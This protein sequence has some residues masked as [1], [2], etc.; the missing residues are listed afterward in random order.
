MNP[1]LCQK[2]RAQFDEFLDGGLGPE[3][4]VFITDHLL[5]CPA[6]A[7][8]LGEDIRLGEALPRAFAVPQEA[9]R[10]RWT[11]VAWRTAAAAALILVG[12]GVGR[13][14][15]S[16]RVPRHTGGEGPPLAG[17]NGG[18]TTGGGDVDET[19]SLLY[20]SYDDV[21]A[22]AE[23]DGLQARLGRARLSE[24]RAQVILDA[25]GNDSPIQPANVLDGFIQRV[26]LA[27]AS[28]VGSPPAGR[29]D[30]LACRRRAVRDLLQPD[31][32]VAVPLISAWVESAANASER[33]IAVQLLAEVG[34]AEAF[35]RL[36]AEAKS[37]PARD[38]A[39]E[40]LR[41]ARD[42]RSRK[43][44]EDVAADPT[45]PRDLVEIAVGG[46]HRMGDRKALDRLVAMFHEANGPDS[47]ATRRHIIWDVA[48]RPTPEALAVLPE[49][50]GSADLETRYRYALGD[51]LINS[52]AAGIQRTLEK[53][54]DGA[55]DETWRLRL[56]HHFKMSDGDF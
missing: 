32:A 24:A 35:P 48:M 47:R 52:G 49:L 45:A 43:L 40:G 11:P 28:D 26:R 44:F 3:A 41:S 23:I 37:G 15:T 39:L 25:R 21:V 1:V 56:K 54:V 42:E 50:I 20:A 14:Q 8:Y 6:C 33:R 36:A 53:L 7:A 13:L 46:L 38:V 34:G 22:T 51:W 16:G 10:R 27:L 18:A 31:R 55:V 4:E 5:D 19:P 9:P 29:H 2:A 17:T 12:F 30:D